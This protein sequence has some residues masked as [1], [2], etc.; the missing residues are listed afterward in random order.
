MLV[1]ARRFTGSRMSPD[2]VAGSPGVF[3]KGLASSSVRG[4]WGV[5]E[6][7]DSAEG[8]E[9]RWS[10]GSIGSHILAGDTTIT[11]STGGS[12]GVREG[13][14]RGGVESIISGHFFSISATG[15]V[16]RCSKWP[17]SGDTD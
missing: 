9:G 3:G 11:N 8:G 2:R 12:T 13:S 5:E 15:V 4:W 16:G 14:F 7:G 17:I 10:V 1:G 6:C